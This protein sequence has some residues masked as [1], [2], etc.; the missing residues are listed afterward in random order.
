MQIEIGINMQQRKQFIIFTDLDGTLLDHDN[1]S[2]NDAVD[3]LARLSLDNIPI[4][5]VSSKTQS[6]IEKISMQLRFHH[7]SVAENGAIINIG[8]HH[9]FRCLKSNSPYCFGGS[10]D[11]ILTSIE[12]IP[13]PMKKEFTLLK[14]MPPKMATEMTGLDQQSL[15]VC[16]ERAYSVPFIASGKHISKLKKF[17]EQ[18]GIGITQGGR[19]YHFLSSNIGKGHST[20]WLMDK[21]R[22]AWPDKSFIS[23]GLGDSY[24]D[25]PMLKEVDQAVVIKNKHHRELRISLREK[26]VV[27]SNSKG[28]MGWAE[29]IK[30]IVYSE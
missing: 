2:F 1:Y 23:I 20:R 13:H 6:E 12:K 28:P 24:N 5:L 15:E 19:F 25:I 11:S 27:E 16:L 14:D 26:K 3:I 22:R 7:A 21:T 4:I 18:L 9:I 29:C 10:I 8:N 30:K 17:C